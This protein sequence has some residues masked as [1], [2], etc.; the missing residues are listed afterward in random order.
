M[1]DELVCK[2]YCMTKYF[3]CYR[4]HSCAKPITKYKTQFC[5][6][7]YNAC[8]KKCLYELELLE[9]KLPLWKMSAEDRALFEKLKKELSGP[10]RGDVSRNKYNTRE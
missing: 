9:E 10:S 7:E 3:D 4:E 5:Q 6:N 2:S 8:S 1:E